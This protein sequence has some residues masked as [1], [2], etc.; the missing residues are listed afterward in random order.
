M[1]RIVETAARLGVPVLFHSGD[2]ASV[3]PLEL[4]AAAAAVPEAAVV[5]AHSGG[6]AHAREALDVAS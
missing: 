2:E 5:F 4:A 6:Y 3:T 1:L